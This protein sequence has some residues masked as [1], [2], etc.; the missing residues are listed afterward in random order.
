MD[1]DET[2]PFFL[3]R[4]LQG[5]EVLN[6]GVHGFGLG[7]MMLRLE[8]EI[9]GAGGA[10]IVVAISDYVA[11]QLKAHYG[12]PDGRIRTI[13]NAVDPDDSSDSAR[14]TH[15]ETI[16]REFGIGPADCLVLLVAH[17]FRLKGVGRWM[18][19]LSRLVKDGTSDVRSIVVGKGDSP[20]WQRR[21]SHLGI[22]KFLTFAGPSQRIREFFH[23]ADVLVHPT[24]YD[25]CSRVVLEAMSAGLAC[26]TTRWDG[27]SEEIEDGVSGFVLDDP[28]DVATLSNRIGRLCDAKLRETFSRNCAALRDSLHM[29]RHAME[30]LALYRQVANSRAARL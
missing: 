30:F 4:S 2:I 11:R 8:R 24:Y 6:F 13:R 22:S 16:R 10:P 1:D 29:E 12:L 25:P 17:N 15:R 23:A 26:V 27:A 14:L 3:E 7:Q 5:A 19:A 9:M 18:E 21:A 20:A 28:G